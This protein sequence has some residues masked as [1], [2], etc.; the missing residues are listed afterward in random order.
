MTAHSSIPLFRPEVLAA[1]KDR[2][3]GDISLAVPIPWQLISFLLF[4]AVIIAA[5][6]LASA[7]YSQVTNVDGA[8]VVDKGTAPI[9]ATRAGVVA[10]VG[11]HDGQKV[12]TG[13][14]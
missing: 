2:L 1:R 10:G 12:V 8:I 14:V 6:F 13:E 4:A 11:V 3:H 7:S 5:V 9:V